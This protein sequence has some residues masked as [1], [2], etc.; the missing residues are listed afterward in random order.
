MKKRLRELL[1]KN[2]FG[3]IAELAA[4]KKRVLGMLVS[5]TFDPDP[6]IAWRAVEAMGEGANRIADYNPDYVRSHLRRLHWLLNE[7]SGGICLYAPQAM[8]EII[9]RRPQMFAD[10]VPIVTTL[11]TSMAEEDLAHFRPSVLWAVGTLVP[12]ARDEVESVVAAVE[13]GLDDPNPQARGMAV[14]CLKRVGRQDLFGNRSE[15]LSDNGPVDFYEN[16]QL[17]R[18]TVRAIATGGSPAK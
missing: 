18:T 17:E 15:L 7:E 16:R 1:E 3:D 5:L 2:Q 9:R 14:W 10:F 6:L 8:A 13:R 12:V 4:G 11:L